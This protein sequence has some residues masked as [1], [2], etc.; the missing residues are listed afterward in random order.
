MAYR[1]KSVIYFL[2]TPGHKRQ[3][4]RLVNGVDKLLL[5]RRRL[6][7]RPLHFDCQKAAGLRQTADDI[8]NASRVAGNIR[9]VQLSDAGVLVLVAGDVAEAEIVED[10]LLDVLFENRR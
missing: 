7:P 2:H 10:L 5:L 8:G 3:S 9:P 1:F 6:V 4:P